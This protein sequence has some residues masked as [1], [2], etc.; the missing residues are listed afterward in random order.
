[1]HAEY[2]AVFYSLPHV[3]E[4]VAAKFSLFERG[5]A[6]DLLMEQSVVQ[7]FQKIWQTFSPIFIV[8]LG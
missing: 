5:T 2:W 1:M 6:F 8:L 3:Q 4:T 7:K